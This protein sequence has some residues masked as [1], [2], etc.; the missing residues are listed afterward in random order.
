M[1]LG[2]GRTTVL[3]MREEG[4]LVCAFNFMADA[5][6]PLGRSQLIAIV[7]QYCVTA[8]RDTPFTGDEPG[9]GWLANFEQRHHDRLRRRHT[10]YL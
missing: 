7:K 2:S 8:N 4:L 3:S 5:G 1:V 6:L 10:E 9:K